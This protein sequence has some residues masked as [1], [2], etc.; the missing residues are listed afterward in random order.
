MKN[1][2]LLAVLT[3][4][5]FTTSA[6]TNADYVKAL[7]NI[8][9][10]TRVSLMKNG[11]TLT[12]LKNEFLTSIL[13]IKNKKNIVVRN[14]YNYTVFITDDRAIKLVNCFGVE[15]DNMIFVTSDLKGKYLKRTINKLKQRAWVY[16]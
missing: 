12:I 10:Q 5:S 3:A 16:H 11:D 1:L 8:S 4:L 2:L 15:L 14:P 13:V 7:D 6:Q 9:L